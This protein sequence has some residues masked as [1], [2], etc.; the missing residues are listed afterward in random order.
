MSEPMTFDEWLQSKGIEWQ[1]RWGICLKFGEKAWDFNGAQQAAA[2]TVAER[3]RAVWICLAVSN[4][5]QAEAEK[6]TPTNERFQAF[7][8]VAQTCARD[9]KGMN[10]ETIEDLPEMYEG[11]RIEIRQTDDKWVLG[12]VTRPSGGRVYYRKDTDETATTEWHT[13]VQWFGQ[14]WRIATQDDSEAYQRAVE[15]SDE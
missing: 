2:A 7:A 1:D 6:E 8:L 11:R 5:W 9:I 14:S 3:E 4:R 10:Q 13:H 15:V 12:T